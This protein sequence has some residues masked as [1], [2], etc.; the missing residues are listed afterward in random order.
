M[1]ITQVLASVAVGDLEAAVAW[2]QRVF[3]PPTTR[4]MPE[5]AEWHWPAGGGL[6]VYAL[7]ERAGQGSFT[8]AV[9]DIDEQAAQL[10]AAGVSDVE[11]VRH[12]QVETIMIRDPDGN[13]IAF[14]H[15]LDPVD[16]DGDE[17]SGAAI[18]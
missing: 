1:A 12:P 11:P 13:S 14:A 5:V 7:A 16:K 15:P 6:Q 18:T 9:T 3:G 8:V 10:R 17:F 2:Y 4:P